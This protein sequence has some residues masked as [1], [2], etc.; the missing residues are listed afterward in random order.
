MTMV[1]FIWS[2]EMASP[3]KSGSVVAFQ[4]S[5]EDGFYRSRTLK[6]N[7]RREPRTQKLLTKIGRILSD[8]LT[9]REVCGM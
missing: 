9:P 7:L 5:P 6:I 8:V 3:D 1:M 2:V 4:P